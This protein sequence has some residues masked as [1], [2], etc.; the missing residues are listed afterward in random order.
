MKCS[1]CVAVIVILIG[2]AALGQTD[3]GGAPKPLSD[4]LTL[5]QLR[6]LMDATSVTEFGNKLNRERLTRQKAELPIWW[7]DSV[8]SAMKEA[9]LNVDIV[10]IYYRF[11]SACYSKQEAR[12]YIHLFSTPE[13]HA[14]ARRL[15]GLEDDLQRE[16]ET[17]ESARTT[18]IS[19]DRGLNP[20]VIRQLDAEDQAEAKAIFGSPRSVA[21]TTCISDA[22]PKAEAAAQAIQEDAAKAV[23]DAH[24]PELD[25]AHI[26]YLTEH[27]EAQ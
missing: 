19:Q 3:S 12:M 1:I 13:G 8:W 25:A 15:G 16:G 21:I 10:P 17:P 7:P 6:E 26:K 22:L 20:A 14:Y 2:R 23:I 18:A 11:Y 27:P 5:S 24:R 4:A 9:I